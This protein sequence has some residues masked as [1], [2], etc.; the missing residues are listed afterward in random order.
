MR[1]QIIFSFSFVCLVLLKIIPSKEKQ[2]NKQ[3]QKLKQTNKKSELQSHLV[4][5]FNFER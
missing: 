2:T 5:S 3:K 4:E 1:N